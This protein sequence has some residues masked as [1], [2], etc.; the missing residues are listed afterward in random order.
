MYVCVY[1]SVLQFTSILQY[2]FFINKKNTGN[3]IH[4]NRLKYEENKQLKQF[5][6]VI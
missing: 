1:D 4:K 2:I 6:S 5:K 3:I